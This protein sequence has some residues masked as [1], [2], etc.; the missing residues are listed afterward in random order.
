M[1]LIAIGVVGLILRIVAPGS[2]ELVLSGLLPISQE[3][4]DTVEIDSGDASTKLIKRADV[5]LVEND[6]AFLPK[7]NQFWA[8]VADTPQVATA[9]ATRQDRID[10]IVGVLRSGH[11]S[12]IKTVISTSDLPRPSH[13]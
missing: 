13:T 3:V 11:H 8:A 5:W 4:V 2:N 1:A 6:P 9:S 7:L 10:F 12:T